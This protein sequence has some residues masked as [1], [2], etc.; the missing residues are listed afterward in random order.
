[1]GVYGASFYNV[2]RNYSMVAIKLPSNKV[3]KIVPPTDVIDCTEL[4]CAV[5]GGCDIEA[6]CPEH[7][8]QENATLRRLQLRC[9]EYS[10]DNGE[11]CWERLEV[12]CNDCG[13]E[14][15]VEGL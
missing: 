12:R 6:V 2:V 1:M 11:T 5:C 3:V 10:Y 9:I 8:P 15:E 13:G 4:N 14:T 7:G